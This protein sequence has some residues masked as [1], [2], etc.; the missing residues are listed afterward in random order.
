MFPGQKEP[1]ISLGKSDIISHQLK[2]LNENSINYTEEVV[3]GSEQGMTFPTKIGTTMCNALI[4]TGATRR[5]MSEKYYKKLQLA[6]IH[7][8]QNVN[9]K[10]VTSSNLAPMGLVNCTFK[11][12]ETEFSS[13]FIVCK[14]LTRPLIL[15]RD[16]LI[17]NHV[18]VRYSENGKCILDYQQQELIVSLNVENKPQLS[19]ANS[20]TLPGR[21]VAV[22]HV[23][24]NL[25]PE[26]SGQMYEIEQN[27]FLTEEY[28]NL[29]IIPLRHNVD[30]Y[31]TENVQLV[32]MNFSTDSVYPSKGEIMGFMQEE[33]LNISE[34]VTE[35]S[36]EPSPILLEEDDDIEGLQE[37][38]RKIISENREK[39]FITSP[40]DIEVHRKVELQDADVTEV[41]QNAFRELCNGFKDIFSIDSSDIGKTPLIEMEIDTGNS[42]PITQKTL[43]PS[44]KTCYM[45]Q[46]ELEILEKAGV[47]VRSVSPWAS[48]IVIVPKRTALREPPKRR[49]CVDY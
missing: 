20:I 10:S 43:Y 2:N 8:L 23:N 40:A 32:V 31:K 16:F 27:Y 13:D 48:P 11:L 34:I 33:S 39:K 29:Y 7:L 30:I 44:F 3:I 36:T 19:L 9:V 45:E 38:K 35:T 49:P 14:N 47:I 18:S 37:Q 15:G 41:Q 25:K 6:K 5:C 12:G 17:Q 42:P 4:D 1:N 24:N 21:T 26:Q 28:P 22:I 46:K